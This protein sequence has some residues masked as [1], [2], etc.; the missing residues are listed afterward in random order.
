MITSFF[1][2][3][4]PIYFIIVFFIAL[5]AFI[6]AR[7][8][9]VNETITLEFV[10]KQALLL[11]I[12]FASI[13]LLNFIVNKNS[14]TNKSNY[15]IVL[16]SLFLLFITQT[17]NHS[18]VLLSNFF[19]L[20]G[21]RRIVSLRSP[22]NTKKKLFDA[23]F[24]IAIAALFYFWSILFFILIILSL[25]LYTD[26]NIR[27]WIIPFLGV[28]AV[29]ILSFSVSVVLYDSFFEIINLSPEISYDFSNYNSVQYLIAIT[30]LLSFGIWS[31]IFYSQNIKKKKKAFRASFKTII[32]AAIIGFFIVIQA[33]DKNGSEFLFL[34]APL[35]IIIANYI[36]IIQEKW[37]KEI[38]LAVLV[39][40]P[41]LLLLL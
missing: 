38:F 12:I 41:F 2:K 33:P 27:H 22:K 23:A 24:W 5:L 3:S 1:N 37:F 25:V 32:L 11:F 4:R 26:N 31:S 29:F 18:N 28:F 21:L 6:V 16:F 34:F 17:T 40:A 15:E 14:L 13:L 20:I 30:L 39:I 10:L 19:V 36:D 9:R 7:I 8:N 35:A